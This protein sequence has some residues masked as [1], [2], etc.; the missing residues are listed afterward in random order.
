MT[1]RTL[2]VLDRPEILSVLFYPRR[3]VGIPRLGARVH[4][5]RIAVA[6]GI[7]VGG[8]VFAAPGK[9]P[10]VL[11]FHG[12]GEIAS[13]YEAIAPFYTRLG[14]TL[15]VV[16][17]RG[18]GSSDGV[19]T[20]SALLADAWVTYEQAAAVLGERGIPS[21]KLFLMGRSLGSAAALEIADRAG[22]GVAGLILESGFAYTFPLI[23]RIGQIQ[24]PDANEERDGFG[25]LAKMRRVRIPT[26][27]LHGERDWI[28]PV[29]DGIALHDACPAEQKRLITVPGA[30]HNDLML[31]GQAQ[32]FGAV[33]EF[34]GAGGPP[35]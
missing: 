2:T 23:E 20:A 32:Y 1:E 27:V 9:A 15:F 25:N 5:V 33:A 28:I 22:Q 26:L 21:D 13:D 4:T 7:H 30:G 35:R 10:V 18:Y 24:V 16:D 12:N 19:P 31:V 34:C 6:E 3:D 29:G 17:Y 8:K 11:Y 14:I